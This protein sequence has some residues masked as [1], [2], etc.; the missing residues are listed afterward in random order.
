MTT[1]KLRA[2][3]NSPSRGLLGFDRIGPVLVYINEKEGKKM[4]GKPLDTARDFKAV[5]YHTVNI[6]SGIEGTKAMHH[7]YDPTPG[8]GKDA[9]LIVKWGGHATRKNDSIVKTAGNRLRCKYTALA[10]SIPTAV[11]TSSRLPRKRFN[12]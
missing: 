6:D 8:K 9:G 1:R 11:M 5:V 4:K 7:T 3:G 10:A 2:E 12:R